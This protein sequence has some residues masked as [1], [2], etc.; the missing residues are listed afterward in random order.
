MTA[1]TIPGSGN[2]EVRAASTP[3]LNDLEVASIFFGFFFALFFFTALKVMRQTWS[4]WSRTKRFMIF[5]L[6]M[7]WVEITV[8]L[9]FAITTYLYL[10]GI[11]KPRLVG[12]L[13]TLHD[14][15][16]LLDY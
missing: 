12:L 15:V 6:W 5:Y 2:M 11:I 16:G 9:I 3:S 8:N 14:D 10:R 4:I 1:T 13:C 7:I